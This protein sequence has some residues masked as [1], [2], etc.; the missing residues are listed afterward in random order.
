MLE[1]IFN[2]PHLT[3]TYKIELG[4]KYC[5]VCNKSNALLYTSQFPCIVC[6]RKNKWN[7]L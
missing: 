3:N 7:K 5:K 2:N 1:E 6:E 4:I